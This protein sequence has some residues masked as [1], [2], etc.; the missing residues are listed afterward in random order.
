MGRSLWTGFRGR[1]VGLVGLCVAGLVALG[2]AR[3]IAVDAVKIGS[4]LYQQI[5]R[6]KALVNDLTAPRLFIREPYI[7]L[8]E[9]AIESD[10]V[11]RQ[12]LVDRFRKAERDYLQAYDYWIRSL[13]DGPLKET[14]RNESHPLAVELFEIVNREFLPAVQ[15]ADAGAG[16]AT[17]LLRG[18]IRELYE[19]QR[20]ATNRAS[21]L[22]S[23]AAA[24]TETEA[25]QTV[26]YWSWVMFGLNGVIL[27]VVV[28]VGW[29]IGSKIVGPT[30]DLVGRMQDMAEGAGDLTSRAQVRSQ[31]EIGQLARAINTVIERIHDLVV[32]VRESSIQ[33][34]ASST[35]IAATSREQEATMQNLGASTNQIAA[36]VKEITATS[37]ELSRTMNEVNE[38]GKQTAALA[39]AG[40]TGLTGMRSAMQRL[41]DS[42]NSISGKL[43]VVREKAND[44]NAVVTTITKVA[45]QTNLLSIN[46][47][48]E[49]EKAGEYG[50]GFLVVA[51]EIRRLADQ[52]AVATLDIENM[53]RQMQAAVSAGVM[54]MDKFTDEVRTG[55]ARVGEIN[56]Q[57][58]QIIDHVHALNERFQSVNEGTAQQSAGARQINDAMLQLAAGVQQTTAS[59]KEFHTVTVN[60]RDAADGLKQQVSRFTVKG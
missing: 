31:D 16:K 49:A 21:E 50:R 45:D 41:A 20:Q 11:R 1:L 4:P 37:Q 34:Y 46:A 6:E 9:I 22:A 55:V 2:I 54:E 10:A 32:K 28:F 13:P 44:I 47:A 57:M 8:L 56:S 29:W 27:A 52:T 30:A 19:R 53:V 26:T 17:A 7:L 15:G 18:R 5:D 35:E 33:L 23:S 60:L 36:A 38:G 14:L 40:R 59:L 39:A 51:R 25:Q 42:T 12:E 3:S 48:I 43:S 24:R 58:G